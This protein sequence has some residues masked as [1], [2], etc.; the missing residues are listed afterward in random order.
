MLVWLLVWSMLTAGDGLLYGQM[1]MVLPWLLLALLAKG[2]IPGRGSA[3]LVD[4]VLVHSGS[5]EQL[6]GQVWAA[7]GMFL[8]PLY[9]AGSVWVEQGTP[10]SEV[11]EKYWVVYWNVHS[12]G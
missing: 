1:G 2:Y 3:R 8:T 5:M 11:V 10:Q 12:S 9:M 4:K 6:V 7:G